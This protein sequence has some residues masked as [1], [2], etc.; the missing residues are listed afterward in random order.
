MR[1]SSFGI[2]IIIFL[3]C[4]INIKQGFALS[5]SENTTPAL[6][7][8]STSAI[9]YFNITW[10]N[11]SVNENV[12][13]VNFTINNSW[14]N[15]TGLSGNAGIPKVY[16]DSSRYFI[17]F[18]Q[19]QL[20]PAGYYEFH[21][22]AKND[23]NKWNDTEAWSFTI[24]PAPTEIRLWLNDSEGNK[25]Y[26][27]N[28]IANFT[29]Q[30]NA[31]SKNVSL[32]SSC[33]S[34]TNLTDNSSS[35]FVSDS[36]TLTCA[37]IFFVN[38]SWNGD[39]NYSASSRT[40]YISVANLSF[41]NN[42]TYPPSPTPYSQT[43]SYNFSI[44][45]IGNVS[46]II[47]E[48]NFLNNTI[49]D[50]TANSSN[51]N[52]TNNSDNY[53]ISFPPLSA[54]SSGYNYRWIANDNNNITLSSQSNYVIS[55]ISFSPSFLYSGNGPSWTEA[56]STPVTLTCQSGYPVNLT[57]TD[58]NGNCLSSTVGNPVSCAFT[59]GS[60]DGGGDYLTCSVSSN[61]NYTGSNSG[62]IHWYQSSLPTTT[63]TTGS[64]TITPSS[65]SVELEPGSTETIT[66][67]LKNTFSNDMININ[68]SIS[69]LNSSWYSLDKTTIAR[70]RRDGGND[71]VKLTLNI[72]QDAER[73]TYNII[74]T[75]SGKDGFTLN[76]IS[77]QT[78]ITLTILEEE[79]PQNNTE[80]ATNATNAPTVTVTETGPT[81]FLIR[82]E[83]F[84]NIV[85]FF[86]LI[87]IGLVFIFRDKITYTLSR[88]RFGK[89][90]FQPKKLS[91]PKFEFKRK[92]S[93]LS[94]LRLK[95][96]LVRKRKLK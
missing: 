24:S 70:L 15:L 51:Y 65:S 34:W 22:S 78:T 58:T 59:T 63:T 1:K 75:A 92:F 28:D 67:A 47:F 6:S 94:K 37:G 7:V 27:I 46:N 12:T 19:Y 3:F 66:L 90:T 79:V 26:K 45:L 91:V 48:A 52:I 53:W 68:I 5:Y 39:Q 32:N 25:T 11:T 62:W 14:Y 55:P 36:T 73:K 74:V 80:E 76:S 54:N 64:F 87:A 93:K 18:T 50:Y 4:L 43:Q 89:K 40:Y 16:Q 31:S 81:A 69:G 95:I 77:R 29:A 42:I 8:Y 13:D 56:V 49:I 2:V 35:S 38:A 21:W 71:T 85:L 96:N 60:N 82:P 23:T 9:Y 61:S 20:G 84:R 86:G 30:L 83:D 41:S 33:P 44:T 88:G 10:A 17:N 57:I 72:P